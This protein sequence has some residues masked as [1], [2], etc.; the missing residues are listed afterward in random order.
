MFLACLGVAG[1]QSETRRRKGRGCCA[2]E[3]AGGDLEVV[4]SDSPHRVLTPS[5]RVLR[6]RP[7]CLTAVGSLDSNSP[8]R[9]LTPS[10]RVLRTRPA[11]L[12]AVGRLAVDVALVR[13]YF[14]VGAYLL[15]GSAFP[16]RVV[17]S[18]PCQFQL[19]KKHHPQGVMLFV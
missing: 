12:T 4:D 18:N 5:E 9:V 3:V 8:H 16:L 2:R 7:A 11:A 17:C 10:G 6:T 15:R 14:V 19:H 13:C 1:E